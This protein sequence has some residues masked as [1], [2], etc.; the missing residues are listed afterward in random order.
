MGGAKTLN[1]H[2]FQGLFFHL[3]LLVFLVVFLDFPAAPPAA[4][5]ASVC[6]VLLGFAWFS[7]GVP[8]VLLG[9]CLVFLRLSFV[10]P[11]ALLGVS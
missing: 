7:L 11:L 8:L 2:K 3:V 4:P 1:I 5:A 10:F 9:F 6:V